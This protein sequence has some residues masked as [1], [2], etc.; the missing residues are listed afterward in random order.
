MNIATGKF[1]VAAESTETGTHTN[2][3]GHSHRLIQIE[4]LFVEGW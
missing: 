1:Y 4:A 3:A 2:A